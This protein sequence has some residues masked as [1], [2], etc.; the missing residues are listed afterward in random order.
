MVTPPGPSTGSGNDLTTAELV[1]VPRVAL[2]APASGEG[3]TTLSIGLMAALRRRG[4]EVAPFKTG[5]DYIDPGY[6]A[7]A[8]GRPGRNL[9]AHLTSP[10]LLAPLLLHGSRVPRPADISVIEGAMGLFDGQLDVPTVGRSGFA[11]CAHVV[12][13]TRTPLLLVLD[14]GHSTRTLAA[15]AHGLATFD[16]MVGVDGVLLNRIGSE[17]AQREARR[18]MADAGLPVLGC[19]PRSRELMTP[20]RHLGLVPAAERD[21]ASAVVDAAA[22]LVEA[23]VDVDAVIALA[24]AAPALD[25]APWDPSDQVRP[26]EGRPRIAFAAGHAFTFRY[27]ETTELI[28]AAGCEVVEFDPLTAPTLPGG[29]SGLYLGGGFPEVHAA[30]LSANESLRHDVARQVADGLPTVAECAGL[31][32]LCTTLDG[33]PMAG[34]LPVAAAMTPRL[35]L[36]YKTVV[37]AHDSLLFSAGEQARS[38]EFHRTDVALPSQAAGLD[39]A[40]QIGDRVEGLCSPTLHASYQHLHWAGFPSAAQRFAEAAAA[41]AAAGPSTRSG[42]APSSTEP[43]QASRSSDGSG[44][45]HDLKHHGDRDIVPGL[46]DLAVNVRSTEPPAWLAE[47]LARPNRWASYPD[48]RE[49]RAA[50]AARHG[51]DEAMV[52]PTSGAAEA[53]TLVA[54]AFTPRRAVIV[55][56]QFTEPEQALR[57][58]GIVPERVILDAR[59]GFVLHPE[60]IPDDADLVV[61]GNPTNPTGVLHPAALLR[62]LARPGRVLLV[63]EAFMDAIPGEPE[64]LVARQMP[65]LIVTRSLTKTWSLA[66]IRAGCVIGDPDLVVA[67]EA[68]QTAWSVSTPALDAMIA[69]STPDALAEASR[70]AELVATQ[71]AAFVTALTDAGFAPVAESQAPFVLIDTAALGPESQRES[72]Q[73][74]GFAVRRGETF[75]GLGPTHIRLAVRDRAIGRR[76]ADV[77]ATLTRTGRP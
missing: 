40:W 27:A 24:H 16:E 43:V 76:F 54:R 20:S 50:L 10:D 4:L 63:D 47:A 65:G 61:I 52:L 15:V 72:L 62:Q 21:E 55:H 71:R 12:G 74:L 73:E 23:H 6:H 35:T 42:N 38:H 2:A 49:A 26:V 59:D 66:G 18:A 3:K 37:S 70:D 29:T 77:L 44:A 46:I 36:G 30:E 25:C 53:F 45:P 56:P 22:D 11:S 67:L 57:V 28:E 7:L 39:V 17:R 9:D 31:L 32:Y 64:S 1:E 58:A 51:V 33:S 69:C 60:L 41:F 68:Q 14:A 34:A 75:P 13:T 5:P 19:I 8:T 48:A